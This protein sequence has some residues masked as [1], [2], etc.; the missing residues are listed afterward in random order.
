MNETRVKTSKMEETTV[1]K[2]ISIFCPKIVYVPVNLMKCAESYGIFDISKFSIGVI[3]HCYWNTLHWSS[4]GWI[5]V[6]K[7]TAVSQQQ[8]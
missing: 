1:L 3:A 2:P 6:P 8:M 7:K 5:G 4:R